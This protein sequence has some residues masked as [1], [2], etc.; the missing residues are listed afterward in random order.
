MDHI[1]GDFRAPNGQKIRGTSSGVIQKLLKIYLIQIKPPL[2]TDEIHFANT[3]RHQN[4]KKNT[5][6]RGGR[7]YRGWINISGTVTKTINENMYV[8]I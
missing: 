8:M 7:G 3:S 1:L 2:H 6:G 4:N 5:E